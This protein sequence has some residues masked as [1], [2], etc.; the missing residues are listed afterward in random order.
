VVTV[1]GTVAAEFLEA[2][3]L[4]VDKVADI[5]AA[6]VALEQGTYDA[7]VFDAPVLAYRVLSEY[8]NRLELVGGVFAPDP[9][10]IALTEGSDLRES[11]NWALLEMSRDGTLDDIHRVWF[12]QTRSVL[13]VR[14]CLLLAAGDVSVVVW[15]LDVVVIRFR[16]R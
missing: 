9:Y 3:R 1:D 4:S 13:A 15:G 6:L 8:T 16:L 11:V 10:G 14:P 12:D 7:V 2:R 5:D